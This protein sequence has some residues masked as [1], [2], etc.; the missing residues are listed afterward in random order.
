[1]VVAVGFTVVEPFADVDVNVPGVTAILF[2]P[3]VAQ[4]SV[5]VEPEVILEGLAVNELIVGGLLV[6]LTVMV[7]VEVVE[8]SALVA[9][10]VYVVVAVGLILVEPLADVNVNVPGVTAILVAPAAQL[11]VLLL[12]AFML[13]G[14]AV[15]EVIVGTEPLPEDEFEAVDPQPMSPNN[16]NRMR[17]SEQ[18][19]SLGSN[20]RELGLFLRTG[21][22]CPQVCCLGN[23]SRFVSLRS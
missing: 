5:L 10:S 20:F 13:V 8:P 6:A 23:P 19:F 9:V 22:L 7:S 15:K 11:T 16:A 18:I 12:P 1:V 4:L 2:A 14:S 3:A 21:W 17:T